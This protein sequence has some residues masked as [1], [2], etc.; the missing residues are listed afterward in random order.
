MKEN[1]IGIDIGGTKCAVSYGCREGDR[2]VVV[3]KDRFATTVVN[4]R[5]EHICQSVAIMLEK[6]QLN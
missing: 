2:L 5:I 6:L 3:V 1:L 4:E